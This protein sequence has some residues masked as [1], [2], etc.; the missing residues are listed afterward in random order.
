MWIVPS[1]CQ[2]IWSQN[3]KICDSCIMDSIVRK[4]IL[5]CRMWCYLMFHYHWRHNNMLMACVTLEGNNSIFIMSS[6]VVELN[7]H[8]HLST[9]KCCVGI[10]QHALKKIRLWLHSLIQRFII[11]LHYSCLCVWI[12]CKRM[13]QNFPYF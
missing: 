10:H 4:I 2:Q 3:F 13:I 5:R 9:P 6:L 11:L 8:K 12:Y 1:V 7:A